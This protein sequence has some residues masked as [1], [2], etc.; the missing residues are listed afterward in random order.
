[1]ASQILTCTLDASGNGQVTF[2]PPAAGKY[3]FLPSPASPLIGIY[4]G[5][6][7]VGSMG[8]IAINPGDARGVRTLPASVCLVR[9]IGGTPGASVTLTVRPWTFLDYFYWG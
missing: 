3:V 7:P 4:Q 9:W 6:Q 5:T 2:T 8:L 1:M